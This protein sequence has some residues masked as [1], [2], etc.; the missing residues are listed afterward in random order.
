M[1]KCTNFVILTVSI[2]VKKRGDSLCVFILKQL[3][4]PLAVYYMISAKLH[5]DPENPVPI[6]KA[7]I[8]I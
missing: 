3:R 8:I 2:F 5:T 7:V 6:V 4:L 1:K